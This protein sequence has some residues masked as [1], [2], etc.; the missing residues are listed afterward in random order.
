MT[1]IASMLLTIQVAVINS[2]DP[3][4]PHEDIRPEEWKSLFEEM[5]EERGIQYQKEVPQEQQEEPCYPY[6]EGKRKDQCGR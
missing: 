1:F 2:F 3:F 4:L 5:A 6:L